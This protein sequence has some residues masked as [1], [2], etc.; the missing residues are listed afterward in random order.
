MNFNRETLFCMSYL[1]LWKQKAKWSSSHAVDR[2]PLLHQRDHHHLPADTLVIT[3][4]LWKNF[5]WLI[6][7]SFFF[8]S[9][10]FLLSKNSSWLV[11]FFFC[12]A[13]FSQEIALFTFLVGLSLLCRKKEG[14]ELLFWY[15]TEIIANVSLLTES[16]SFS[17]F[18][19][20]F[21]DNYFFF[22]ISFFWD[23]FVLIE[24]L[25]EA[26]SRSQPGAWVN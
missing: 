7:I 11:F 8:T 13:F 16:D 2:G 21:F 1:K 17:V 12:N 4:C 26:V 3:N 18:I 10:T 9:W 5:F 19:F 15:R 25:Y 14:L 23:Q 20:N 6:L 22:F 24:I